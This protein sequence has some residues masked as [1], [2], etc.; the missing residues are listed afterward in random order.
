ME[1]YRFYTPGQLRAASDGRG[2][3]GRAVLYGARSVLLPDWEHGM[4]YEEVSRGAITD[5]LLAQSDIVANIN[6]DDDRMLAR[7]V[8]GVGSLHLELDDDG[9]LVRFDAAD[10]IWGNYALESVRRGDFA[11]MSFC[12]SCDEGDFSY[13]EEPDK[14]GSSVFVRHLNTIRGLYD[15]SIV[16][17]P[18]YPGTDVSARSAAVRSALQTAGLLKQETPT[19]SP[20][21]E[22]VRGDFDKIGAWLRRSR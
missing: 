20:A 10:T 1:R 5:A 12:F 15:V 21:P 8:N 4:V 9:L 22:L 13:T 11:G 6:H 16:T 2:I 7:S 17:H 18:A 14:D 3:E 19:P